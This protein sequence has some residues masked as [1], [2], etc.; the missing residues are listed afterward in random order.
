MLQILLK[1]IFGYM[2][3]KKATGNKSY[4]TNIIAYCDS[5]ANSTD[6]GTA[7]DAVYPD[8]SMAFN[9]VHGNF[10]GKKGVTQTE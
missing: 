10:V 3:K 4:L 7:V 6:N 9:E 5:M 1:V 2:I 8:F